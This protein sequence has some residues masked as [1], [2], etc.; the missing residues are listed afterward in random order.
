[1]SVL[2][3]I[4]SAALELSL[5][6]PTTV[7]GSTE[8]I[9][10]QLLALLVRE[11]KELRNKM[12][13]PELN[14]EYTFDLAS[15]TASY[16]IPGDFE[17]FDFETHWDRDNHWELLGP[18][19]PSEWQWRKS[20]IVTN[21]PRRRY[22]IKGLSTTQFFID[23]IPSSG[24]TGTTLVFEYQTKNWV[25]PTNWL[26]STIYAA[27]ATTFNEGNYYTTASGGTSGSTAPTH[28][29]GTSSD[30][31]VLWTFSDDVYETPLADTDEL[32]LDENLLVL[33]VKWRFMYVKGLDWE[34][35]KMEYD[36]AMKR[37]S[38]N[39]SSAR[40]LYFN[41]PQNTQFL[42]YWNIQDSGY[43]S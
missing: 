32:N 18:L 5:S 40:T 36:N 6:S 14:R 3:A 22:R 41:D 24:D 25:R 8:Q 33:G 10:Q 35:H 34:V 13:W 7:V 2:S 23:P 19:T 27:G 15:G 42:G 21:A 26:A 29:T 1:M 28:T 11:G 38:T 4:Q 12:Y 43:G 20:G 30:D 31:G 37:I 39:L 16:A 17:R 9:T